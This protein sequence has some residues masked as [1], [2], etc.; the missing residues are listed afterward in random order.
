[1]SRIRAEVLDRTGH[2]LRSEVR[3]LGFDVEVAAA[4]GA[5][6]ATSAGH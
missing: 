3:L 4:A 1:M 5:R 2:D 6:P